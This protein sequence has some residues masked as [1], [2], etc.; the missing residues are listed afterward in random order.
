MFARLTKDGRTQTY[1]EH[2]TRV[3]ELCRRYCKGYWFEDIAYTIGKEHDIGKCSA[4]WQS[5][6]FGKAGKIPHAMT[7][8]IEIYKIYSSVKLANIVAGHHR[9]LVS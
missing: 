5:Y 8:A 7:G 6:L 3:A 1:A 2:S 9:G 4:D